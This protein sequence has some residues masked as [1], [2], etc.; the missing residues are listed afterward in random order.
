MPFNTNG[1][2]KPIV[3]VGGN[4][5]GKT[6]LLSIIADALIECAEKHYR[7]VVR[8]GS[9]LHR[10]WFRVVGS[11]TITV[12]AQGSCALLQF[13]HDGQI[14]NFRE[15]GGQLRVDEVVAEL[16]EELRPLAAWNEEGAVKEFQIE[17]EKSRAVFEEGAYVYFPAS[18]YEIPNWLNVESLETEWLDIGQRYKG[19]LHK[20]IYVDRGINK[21][22]QWMLSVLL[23]SRCEM[24]LIFDK[25]DNQYKINPSERWA[26]CLPTLVAWVPAIHAILQ[27]IFDDPAVRLVSLG[28]HAPGRLAVCSGDAPIAPSLDALSAGQATLLTV[29]GTLLRYGD[30]SRPPRAPSELEGICLVDEI[31]AHMHIDLQHRALPR[32][33]KM[34]PKVQFIVSSHSPIFV[35]GM[36]KTLGV[37]GV[38]V[39]EMPSGAPIHAETY[40]EFEQ[41]LEVFRETRAFRDEIAKGAGQPGKLLVLLEG[42]TDP[43]YLRTAAELLNREEL[44]EKVDFQWVGVKDPKSGQGF[45]T[46]KDALNQA[47][48][49]FRANPSAV[50]GHILLLYDNDAGK[51]DEDFGMVHVRSVPVNINNNKI[52]SGIENLLPVESIEDEMYG[53]KTDE[54]PD[55]RTITTRHIK[56]MDLCRYLC[57]EKRDPA[58]FTSFKDVLDMVERLAEGVGAAT[59]A[60]QPVGEPGPTH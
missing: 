43:E 4:G 20:S 5:S 18:R 26:T 38:A 58:D 24:T 6:N 34:F 23:D 32:L 36:E 31:D 19:M 45:L 22:L 16:P 52:R 15:K 7:N 2:P 51:K 39:L 27:A 56:K 33:I 28:R 9:E 47:L 3:L 30:I 57:R 14:Y 29:F 11:S 54:K 46:G 41:A 60:A 1:T 17:E 40:A 21:I 13:D 25:N 8:G 59:P 55:G 42:E 49:V 35:L 50:K 48:K 53:E 37:D 10:Q 44:L 12:G